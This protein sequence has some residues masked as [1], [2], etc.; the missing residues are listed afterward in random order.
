MSCNGF[1]LVAFALALGLHNDKNN[2]RILNCTYLGS[3]DL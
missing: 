3:E 2:G 1:G